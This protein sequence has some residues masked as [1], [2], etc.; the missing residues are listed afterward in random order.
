[1]LSQYEPYLYIAET[2]IRYFAVL[3]NDPEPVVIEPF[4]SRD[5]SRETLRT[6]L[7]RSAPGNHE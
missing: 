6:E 7:H 2:F 4:E 5:Y 3:P 1:M